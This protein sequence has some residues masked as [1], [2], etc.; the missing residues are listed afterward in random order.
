MKRKREKKPEYVISDNGAK[1]HRETANSG[2]TR[3]RD[4]GHTL[5]MLPIL[6]RIDRV[7]DVVV[8]LVQ[9]AVPPPDG[10]RR[11]FRNIP[12]ARRAEGESEADS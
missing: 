8:A 7:G 1:L 10:G 11:L 3:I 5:A 6:N 9:A 12:V 4:A 2:F